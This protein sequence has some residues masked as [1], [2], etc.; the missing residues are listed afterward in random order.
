MRFLGLRHDVP[1][2]LAAVDVLALTSRWEGLPNVVIEAMAT[3]AVAVA[4]DVGGCRELIV[5]GESGF[6]VPPGAAG[7]RWRARC[8]TSSSAPTWRHGCARRRGDRI[9][10]GVHRRAAM[11][12]QDRATSTRTLRCGRPTGCAA[13]P[14]DRMRIAYVIPAYPPLASQPFVV[15]EMIAVQEA[16]HE[17][18]VAA[19]LRS[20]RRPGPARHVRALSA[21]RRAAAGAVRRGRRSALALATLLRHPWR[22]LRT[23]AGLHRGGGEELLVASAARWR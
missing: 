15:N 8:S 10:G 1:A 11:V 21:G 16:G 3:G 12:Q 17:V 9:E 7:R 22:T 2:L 4:T 23:L 18:V 14:P 20:A 19:A 6:L 5:H 13:R